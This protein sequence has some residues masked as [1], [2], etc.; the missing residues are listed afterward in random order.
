MRGDYAGSLQSYREGLE[1]LD[2]VS[3]R[4][5]EAGTGTGTGSG[6]RAMLP[7]SD[8]GV[9]AVVSGLAATMFNNRS[10][11]HLKLASAAAAAASSA[12][13]D[14]DAV[15]KRL[16]HAACACA[17]AS[18]ALL[19]MG[20]RSCGEVSILSAWQWANSTPGAITTGTG[21]GDDAAGHVVSF[22]EP[23]S[24]PTIL[25]ATDSLHW[26]ADSITA[27][28]RRAGATKQACDKAVAGAQEAVSF[29]LRI[30]DEC[31]VRPTMQDAFPA[32]T[33]AG[34]TSAHP[35]GPP[36][37]PTLTRS[38]VRSSAL[39]QAYSDCTDRLSACVV[40]T[41]V[42]QA[43]KELTGEASE[44]VPAGSSDAKAGS[45]A[46][47]ATGMVVKALHRRGTALWEH[48]GDA[49]AA[50]RDML[51]ALALEPDNAKVQA[52]MRR[53]RAAATS[54]AAAA[55]TSAPAAS[56][57]AAAQAA[58]TKI[59]DEAKATT[60]TTAATAAARTTVSAAP[61]SAPAPVAKAAPLAE[62][63]PL[64]QVVAS[65]SAAKAKAQ[66]Q[67]PSS[68]EENPAAAKE[69][70][71]SAPAAH[72]QTALPSPVRAAAAVSASTA[73]STPAKPAAAPT[74]APAS[75]PALAPAP[76]PSPA[77]APAPASAAASMPAS[78]PAPA[79]S[80]SAPAAAPTPVKESASLAAAKRATAPSPLS[81]A[82]VAAAARAAL[83][84]R[85]VAA[86]GARSPAVSAGGPASPSS[87]GGLAPPVNGAAL[88]RELH[89]RSGR[90][91]E[92]TVA[93]LQAVYPTPAAVA[94]AL[95]ALYRRAM[96]PDVLSMLLSAAA[97][98]V[99]N[100]ASGMA[101][102]SGGSPTGSGSSASPSSSMATPEQWAVALLQGITRTP[103]FKAAVM[104]L[105][106]DDKRAVAAVVDAAEAR[107]SAGDGSG[108]DT[109]AA[110]RAAF[111]SR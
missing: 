11:A 62:A 93:Y 8:V 2:A 88:E 111:G 60:G 94:A 53:I 24:T 77:P 96:E 76:V 9:A 27:A 104:M 40:D 18:A 86:S 101:S 33:Q 20:V 95:P 106:G 22:S 79:P 66:G 32:N 61:T 72:A 3:I 1:S 43:V 107:C 92:E 10:M 103:G 15:A 49:S 28:G 69:E 36:S 31:C 54:A 37:I 99:G 48:L 51:A 14:S 26:I 45:G 29:A 84:S 17:D 25:Q 5:T 82:A 38:L 34:G 13:T 35:C 70:P 50:L 23:M 100:S 105:T 7:R 12:S 73:A 63:Q 110:V 19:C 41:N 4:R 58:A 71:A 56:I 102:P 46:V 6:R 81:P 57:E 21:S 91:M 47:A 90:P 75:T 42:A 39:M 87:A 74:P 65:Q 59:V 78:A 16:Y 64:P 80:S 108:A 67:A 55:S 97:A 68:A 52:E 44:T 98:A 85:S 30:A 109:A 89:K 83:A